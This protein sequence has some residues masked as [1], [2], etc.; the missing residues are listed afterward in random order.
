MW[1]PAGVP[2]R[3][4]LPQTGGDRVR[5]GARGFEADAVSQPSHDPVR[6]HRPLTRVRG[7]TSSKPHVRRAFDV[8]LRWK[9]QLESGSK[10]SDDARA[11]P[12]A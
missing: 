5:L 8:L 7:Q 6:E 11:R 9:Q 10:N 4:V 3:K 2:E 1:N 12:R